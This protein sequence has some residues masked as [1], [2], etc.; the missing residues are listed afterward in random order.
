MAQFCQQM[1]TRSVRLFQRL[2][3][4][5]CQTNKCALKNNIIHHVH[6]YEFMAPLRVAP[7]IRGLLLH[8][9]MST[10]TISRSKRYEKNRL[11]EH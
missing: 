1:Q 11:H 2:E 6:V 5:Q 4:Q 8:S 3:S 10:K 9:L 7:F